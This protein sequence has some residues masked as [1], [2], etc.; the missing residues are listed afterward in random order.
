M[1]LLTVDIQWAGYEKDK[2]IIENIHFSLN[3]GET[4]GLLGPNG[5]GK[6]TIIKTILGMVDHKVGKIDFVNKND[7]AYI[8]EHPVFYDELTL[9]E[10]VEFLGTVE[11]LPEEEY[12]K[13]AECLLED[14][15]LKEASHRFPSSFSKGMKQKAMLVF[16]L[17]IKPSVYIID[18]PFVGLDPSAMKLFLSSLNKAK[19]E[20]A[21]ILMS[22]HVLDTAEKVCDR[23]LLIHEGRLAA[24][25]TLEDIRRQSRLPRGSLFDCFHSLTEESADDRF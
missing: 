7:Y 12:R 25:G 6:S 9:W 22:T 15:R 17:L 10:H 19:R 13:R 11:N 3:K 23:F 1:R 16:A 5:A 8:P 20:G 4:I 21:G 2:K 24:A 14:F 18:E